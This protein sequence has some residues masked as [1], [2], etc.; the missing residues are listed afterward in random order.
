VRQ[1]H[2]KISLFWDELK[3]RR[4]IHIITLYASA[5]F[6]LIEL[7]GNLTEP[8]NLPPS[9]S[10][11]VIIVLAVGFLPAIILSW[12]Y[13]LSSG[14]LKRTRPKEEF[15]SKESAQVP[16]AWK[17][18]TILSFVVIVGLVTFNILT[19][20]NVLKPGRIQSLAVLPFENFTGDEQLDYVAAG[21]HSSLIG[22]MGKLGALR[23]IGK[24]SSSIYQGSNKSATEIARELK[25][26]A[27]V[28]P[29]V[30]CYGDSVCLQ[31]K[32]IT[33]YPEEKQIFV[34]EYKVDRS[35]V[36]NLYNQITKQIAEEMMVKIT[37]E[38]ERLLA[39]ARTVDREAFDEY[40]KAHSYW[41]D[42]SRESLQKAQEYLNSAIIKEP[43]WAPLY[44]ALA[45]VW[46][47]LQQ[48]GFEQPTVASSEIYR[49]LNKA[50]ELDPDLS[51][52]HFLRAMIAHLIEWDWEKS[53]K[54]FLLALGVNPSDAQ[55]RML[56]SQLLCALQRTD[57]AK[58]QAQ[59]AYDLDPLDPFM[60]IWYGA[61][62]PALGDCK[63]AVAL[64]E[65]ITADDPANY[66]ANNNIVV[67]AFPCKE[68]DKV[69]KAEKN[70]LPVFNINENEIKEFEMMFKEQGIVRAYEIIMKHL[71]RFAENN[72]ISF[73]DM[74]MRYI[75]A[76]QP[77]KAMNWIE[78]GYEI[79]DPQMTYITS[80]MYYLDP[81][82]TNPKFIEIAD[83]MNLPL[84]QFK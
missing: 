82:F 75:M 18:A 37:P 7:A 56:Y 81:L 9:L 76:D 52:V 72:P 17:I 34:E 24:T 21:M 74:A 23:V 66:I 46:M 73:M 64:S 62:L 11:I 39:K 43:D 45:Q 54:E 58:T 53:E 41:G 13:D 51:E 28:E 79:H 29:A 26:E 61:I 70:L 50:L 2:S 42:A 35:Q 27:L 3:R 84:T 68:Y 80:R 12:I 30:M 33:L 10:T 15:N 69:I 22:D 83:K 31:I 47:G 77:D 40:L 6:V 49:N 36:L 63:T 8:L 5:A 60:K 71:E 4:V 1:L 38:Q 48:M 67:A 59:L 78:K 16:N 32:L 25:V 57:E 55:S 65:E 19:R 20:R 14:T 44:S